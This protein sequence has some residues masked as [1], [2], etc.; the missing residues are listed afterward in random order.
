[1]SEWYYSINGEQFGPVSASELKRLVASGKLIESDLVYKD[2]LPKW[3]PVSKVKGLLPDPVQ[4]GSDVR[5]CPYCGEEIRLVAVKCKHCHEFINREK[6]APMTVTPSAIQP[7]VQVVVQGDGS[8]YGQGSFMPA[9]ASAVA[10]A[11]IH[12][13]LHIRNTAGILALVLGFIGAHKFYLGAWGWGLLYLMFFWTWIPAIIA[14]IEGIV[15]LTMDEGQFNL[16]YNLRRV[17]AFTW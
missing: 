2:G 13:G 14:F 8:V 6:A 11:A 9:G 16:K 5:D 1:M 3:V 15:Y 17:D 7:H 12:P 10:T 4:S